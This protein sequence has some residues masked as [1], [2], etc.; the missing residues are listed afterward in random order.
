MKFMELVK[1]DE[2]TR[3][4]R[5]INRIRCRKKLGTFLNFGILWNSDF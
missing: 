5:E 1:T 4:I 2:M 3:V